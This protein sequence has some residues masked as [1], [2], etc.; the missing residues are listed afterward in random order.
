MNR[1]EANTICVGDEVRTMGNEKCTV[2]DL[3]FVI[4]SNDQN[5]ILATLE[6]QNTGKIIKTNLELTHTV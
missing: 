3:E 4:D 2:V 6:S 1:G 5:G